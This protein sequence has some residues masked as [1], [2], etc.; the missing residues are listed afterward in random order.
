MKK[1]ALLLLIVL[2]FAGCVH[3]EAETNL[4]TEYKFTISESEIFPFYCIGQDD[5]LWRIESNGAY[6]TK[7][8]VNYS[9]G[10]TEHNFVKYLKY[11]D[12]VIFA[13]DIKVQNGITFAALCYQKG[14]S[15]AEKLASNVVI[16]SVRVQNNGNLLFLDTD[17]TLFFKRDGILT[18]IEQDV[19][20]A[21]FVGEDNFLFRLK[22]GTDEKGEMC[23]PIYSATADYRNY[24]MNGAL[25]ASSDSENGKAYIIKNRHTVQKRASS[26]EV[27]ECYVYADGEVLFNIPSVVLS[28][29]END[30]HMF[31]ISCN[32]DE[33][34]LKYDLYRVDGSMPELKATDIISGKYISQ[35]RDVF[36]Y[37]IQTAESVTTNIID[38]TDKVRTYDLGEKCALDKIYSCAPYLYVFVDG[39]LL[40]LEENST[41]ALIDDGINNI[42]VIDNSLVCFKEK[43]PPYSISVCNGI[44]VQNKVK[45]VKSSNI[46]FSKGELYYYTEGNDLNMVDATGQSFAFISNVDT[47]IGYI[48][49]NGT[50]AVAKNDDKTLFIASRFGMC[51]GQ[52]KIKKFITEE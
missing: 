43:T 45:N 48:C 6:S 11:E 21:E 12:M 36:A 4:P 31:L 16:D 49:S 28:Q 19:A 14:R 37:E 42:K 23:Y 3:N 24:L 44:S 27:A 34:T 22:N 30:K 38:H 5:N 52:L 33:P 18:K 26:T 39:E 46:K 8:R 40:M 20:Q 15:E 47:N 29:F 35:K 25:I 41:G 32:E 2:T 10:G 1:I 51:D 7:Y 50:V 9:V 13:T 17:G